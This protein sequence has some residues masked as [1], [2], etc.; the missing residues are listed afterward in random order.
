MKFMH[1]RDQYVD[2]NEEFER[3]M[4]QLDDEAYCEQ[5]VYENTDNG[6]GV[7]WLFIIPIAIVYLFY[8]LGKKS[9]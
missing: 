7:I 9:K 3:C 2:L 5:E 8:K 6:G 1:P 4:S